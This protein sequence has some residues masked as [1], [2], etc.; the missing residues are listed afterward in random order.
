MTH[1]RSLDGQ[2]KQS[3]RVT[4]H[5]LRIEERHRIFASAYQD[6]PY[7]RWVETVSTVDGLWNPIVKGEVL[8]SSRG[9]GSV[10]RDQIPL[11]VMS[12]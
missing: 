11:E 6:R 9:D 3:T 5:Q 12:R 2:L 4:L 1:T 8:I 7:G 10:Q